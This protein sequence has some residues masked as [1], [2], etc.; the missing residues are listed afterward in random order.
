MAAANGQNGQVQADPPAPVLVPV[1]P[2]PAAQTDVM[3]MLT[4]MVALQANDMKM[5]QEDRARE[6]AERKAEK[7]K[8]KRKEVKWTS[9]RNQRENA[10]N[11]AIQHLAVNGTKEDVS[12]LAQMLAANMQAYDSHGDWKKAASELE[13]QIRNKLPAFADVLTDMLQVED[14]GDTTARPAKRASTVVACSGCHKKGHTDASCWTLH[15]ELRPGAQA[16]TSLPLQS[17]PQ[18]IAAL[19][20]PATQQQSAAATAPSSTPSFIPTGRCPVCTKR[21]HTVDECWTKYPEKMPAS[22]RMRQPTA[23][24]SSATPFAQVR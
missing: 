6:E 1:P 13:S 11:L 19:S 16:Q 20:T 7:E 3:A 15:P 18:L 24:A 4:Q 22:M 17:L 14:D 5:R 8:K 23:S 9:K 10:K 2:A 12:A 21:G